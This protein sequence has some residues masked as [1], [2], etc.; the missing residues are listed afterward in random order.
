MPN[1][2]SVPFAFASQHR[3]EFLPVE[4]RRGKS[5]VATLAQRPRAQKTPPEHLPVGSD[6]DVFRYQ[7][8]LGIGLDICNLLYVMHRAP[9]GDFTNA[10]LETQLKTNIG[11]T[12]SSECSGG[13]EDSKPPLYEGGDL[14]VIVVERNADGS[15]LT[16][17]GYDLTGE[18]PL[19]EPSLPIPLPEH[20]GNH[21]RIM[22]RG[23]NCLA[24]GVLTY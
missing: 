18:N 3:S 12:Q 10:V 8:G 11:H 17:R 22:F 7:W 23:D 1:R 24:L 9:E 14:G 4:L 19:G 21:C 5:I 2:T 16:I 20:W 15:T 13:Y 6:P